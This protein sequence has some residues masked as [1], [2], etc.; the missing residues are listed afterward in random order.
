MGAVGR[1]G[2][3]RRA[4]VIYDVEFSLEAA[5]ELIR[6]TEVIGS[7]VLVLQAAEALRRQLEDDPAE[8]ASSYLKACTT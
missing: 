2:K 4:G 6:I 1:E 3:G 5:A 8:K 7:A